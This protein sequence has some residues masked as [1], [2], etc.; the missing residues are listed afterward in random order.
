MVLM[1]SENMEKQIEELKEQYA[2][3]KYNKATNKYLGILRAKIA[4]INKEMASKKGMK[5]KGFAVKKT[6]D[7]TVALVGFPNAGKSSLL[8]ALTNVESKVA[9]YA[10]TT[11]TVIPGMLDINSAKIQILDI[12]GLI[13]GAG[14]G[15]GESA[16]I[17]SVIRVSDLVVFVVDANEYEKLIGLIKELHQLG[18]I[19]GGKKSS[20][21]V[22]KTPTGGIKI[23]GKSSKIED[24]DN[25]KEVLNALGI[26]NAN[27]ILSGNPAI[28]DIVEFLEE[29]NVYMR[30][31]IALNKI[32][33]SKGFMH[34][35]KTLEM[36]TGM[37]VIPIS[38]L[39]NEG[40]GQLKE[41]VFRELGIIRVYLKKSGEEPDIKNPL[42]LKAG[43]SIAD[44]GA[45]LRLKTEKRLR[46]AYI[47]GKSVRFNNQKVGI[48]H[49]VSDKDIVTLL[50]G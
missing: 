16:K 48:N 35:K 19:F 44:L 9:D 31:I 5:G 25:I 6:G 4:R 41:E 1:G 39:A 36:N 22:E 38:A 8:N 24:Q 3:T 18:I 32:D 11:L 46:G 7:A 47:T 26:F 21:N 20:I 40:I 30:G 14:I 34:A 27:V 13:E 42:I 2:K 17:A 43:S 12:P 28:E 15:K 10:F 50:Y 37:K 29:G 23:T 33:I 45:K 49:I